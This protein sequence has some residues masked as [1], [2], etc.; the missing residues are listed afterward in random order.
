TTGQS[1]AVLGSNEGESTVPAL[2][3]PDGKWIATGWGK[4][5]RLWDGMTGRPLG[6]LGSHE[7]TI[8]RLAIIR[9]GQWIASV[10][11]DEK[12]IVL[13]DPA[14]RKR[15]ASLAGHTDRN[16]SLAISPA[17]SRMISATWDFPDP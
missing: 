1:L 9:D 2:F 11:R 4:E 17:G 6:V 14:T 15:V 12:V 8:V 5:I 10:A 16:L 7:H 3:S 13:W